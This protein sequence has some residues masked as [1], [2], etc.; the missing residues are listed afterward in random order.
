[1]VD[2]GEYHALFRQCADH[3]REAHGWRVSDDENDDSANIQ[4]ALT[5]LGALTAMIDDRLAKDPSADVTALV[6][7]ARRLTAQLDGLIRRRMQDD[8]NIGPA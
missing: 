1:V 4:M 8:G 6:R 5:R 2:R 3:A 7:K